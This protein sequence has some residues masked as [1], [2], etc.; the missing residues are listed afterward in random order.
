A[1]GRGEGDRVAAEDRRQEWCDQWEIVS[2]CHIDRL[3]GCDF[4]VFDIDHD[5]GPIDLAT[6]GVG[7][8]ILSIVRIVTTAVTRIF[9]SGIY[10][11]ERRALVSGI[12]NGDIGKIG[13]PEINQS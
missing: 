2:D 13:A 1:G 5:F 11:K 10:R 4:K 7:G 3:A 8:A 9:A 6:A 12:F